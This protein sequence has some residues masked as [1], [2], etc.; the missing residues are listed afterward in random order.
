MQDSEAFRPRPLA[1]GLF[2]GLALV[3]AVSLIAGLG[4]AAQRT[5]ANLWLVSNYLV[6]LSLGGLVLVALTYVSGARWSEPLRRVPEAFAAVLPVAALGLVA[7]LL[8]Q[9]SLYSWYTAP[10]AGEGHE[11]P[12]RSLWLDRPFFLVRALAYL[13]IWLGF[14]AAIVRTSRRQ[15][16]TGEPALTTRN[17]RLSAAFLVA[18]GV[19][20]WLAS[21]DWIMSLEADWSS[22]MFGVYNFAG[23]F[24]SALAAVTLLVIWLRQVS[25]LRAYVSEDHLHDLGTLLF[26]FSSLW[27]YTWFCQYL[28]IWYTNHPEETAYF[29]RRADGAWPVLMLLDLVLNWGIPFL[30]LLFRQAKRR[31]GILAAVCVVVLAG[32]WVDLF[33][34]IFPSQGEALAIP[35]AIEAGLVL[36]AAGVFGLAVFWALAKAP[37][38]PVNEPVLVRQSLPETAP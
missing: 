8:F 34:M 7:V 3:G 38:V 15:D 5:W 21:S 22:T 36:G 14:A 33:V 25:P 23:L 20:C 27:M 18:F 16:Q 28:L 4:L 31:A 10:P 32:R 30:V 1:V 17:R 19:T 6:G 24:L 12:L 37:L 2:L 26:A 29:L 11:S 35:G 9:P 13:G